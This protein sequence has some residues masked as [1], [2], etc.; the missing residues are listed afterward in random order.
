MQRAPFRSLARR[1]ADK[2]RKEIGGKCDRAS[3]I[4]KQARGCRS[5]GI[6]KGK[7]PRPSKLWKSIVELY[8]SQA[9]VQCPGSA[10]R[11]TASQRPES[12]SQAERL[13]P[14]AGFR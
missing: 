4:N 14:F 6:A 3:F 2:I 1:Q 7:T 5:A 13:Q 11:T 12:R 9:R 10:G 8:G